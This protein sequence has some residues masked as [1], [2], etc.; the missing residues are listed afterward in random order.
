M[1]IMSNNTR[2]KFYLKGWLT[3]FAVYFVT[4]TIFILFFHFFRGSWFV[5]AVLSA[6]MATVLV[7]TYALFMRVHKKKP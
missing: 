4:A 3:L 7:L 1:N 6:M 5:G 2:F